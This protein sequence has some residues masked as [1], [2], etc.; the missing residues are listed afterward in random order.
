MRILDCGCGTGANIEMLGRFGCARRVRSLPSR[1]EYRPG[2]GT[3]W[4]GSRL[5]RGGPFPSNAF[6]LVTSFDVLYSLD[7]RDEHAAVAEMFRM[8]RPGGYVPD[9]RR[10]DAYCGAIIPSWAGKSRRA[11]VGNCGGWSRAPAS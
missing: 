8:A 10:R 3:L 9:Q 1:P 5:S 11:A 2:T 6:D 4:A 7:E